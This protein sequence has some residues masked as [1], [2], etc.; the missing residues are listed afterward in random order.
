MRAL[1]AGL[2]VLTT[3]SCNE[4]ITETVAPERNRVNVEAATFTPPSVS[5][6]LNGTVEFSFGP[7]AHQVIFDELPG[8]P[9][10]IESLLAN[11]VEERSF[12]VPGTFPFRCEAAGHGVMRGQVV[13]QPPSEGTPE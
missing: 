4:A 5:V 11:T 12:T 1:F 2:V 10:N 8:R 13:V 6:R 9:D 7:V 3:L